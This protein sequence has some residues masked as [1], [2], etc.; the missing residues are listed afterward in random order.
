M[1]T[2]VGQA[3]FGG[4]TTGDATAETGIL[5]FNELLIVS[6]DDIKR[7]SRVPPRPGQSAV[8]TG[9]LGPCPVPST[10]S[11]DFQATSRTT[12]RQAGECIA[13]NFQ[14]LEYRAHS[15]DPVK[16]PLT[17][18]VRPSLFSEYSGANRVDEGA[19]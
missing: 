4:Q 16:I 14:D 19:R 6:R 2:S 17:C 13:D 8:R 7:R 5:P 10:Q 9:S 18:A 11:G 3:D 12:D 1:V 15:W